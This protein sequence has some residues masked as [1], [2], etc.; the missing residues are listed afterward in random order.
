VDHLPRCECSDLTTTVAPDATQTPEPVETIEPAPTEITEEIVEIE[1]EMTIEMMTSLQSATYIYDGDGNQV[2]SIINNVVTYYVGR[3]YHK[4]VDG[5]N[6]SIKKFYAIGMSQIAV[7]TDG[8]LQWIL[9]D[10]LSSASVSASVD[11]TLVSEVKYSAYGEIRYQ[12]GSLPTKYQYTGQLSQMEEIGLMYFVARWMDPLTGHF[13]QAD[14][15]VPSAGNALTYNRYAY[16]RYNPIKYNDPSGHDVGCP[17]MNVSK[18]GPGSRYNFIRRK[19]LTDF[20]STHSLTSVVRLPAPKPPSYLKFTPP[21]IYKPKANISAAPRPEKPVL[22]PVVPIAQPFEMP[23]DKISRGVSVLSIYTDWAPDL[24]E[25]L[26][27]KNHKIPILNS[28]WKTSMLGFGIDTV[29]QIISDT[30]SHLGI[31]ERAER[32]VLRGIQGGTISLA[33]SNA[34]LVGGIMGGASFGPIG[35][36]GGYLISYLATNM[37]LTELSNPSVDWVYNNVFPILSEKKCHA[38]FDD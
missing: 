2:K 34:G 5:A 1:P 25:G 35:F 31:E 3:H 32:A 7:R 4:T 36:T 20:I 19:H 12:S 8:V 14:T 23:Y 16:A 17:G 22:L 10:H 6:V 27:P 13:V 37:T 26:H 38:R 30:G 21:T 18:C 33:S 15:I 28:Q 11:G 29:S 24:Y 9:T